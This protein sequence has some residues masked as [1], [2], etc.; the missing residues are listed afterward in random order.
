MAC[1]FISCGVYVSSNFLYI[2][3][4]KTQIQGSPVLVGIGV[5]C[6]NSCGDQVISVLLSLLLRRGLVLLQL[7]V[8]RQRVGGL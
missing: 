3:V 5:G 1:A 6:G 4:G 7:A 2:R 8:V